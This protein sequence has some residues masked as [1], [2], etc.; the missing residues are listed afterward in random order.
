MRACAAWVE[1]NKKKKRHTK[2]TLARG[3]RLDFD[4]DV[5][6]FRFDGEALLPVL[7]FEH[8]VFYQ[9]TNSRERGENPLIHTSIP[10]VSFPFDPARL[11]AIFPLSLSLRLLSKQ[12]SE[13]QD[14]KCKITI[15]LMNADAFFA[16]SF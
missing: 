4:A 1:K 12:Q 11:V 16:I 15:K 8:S 9:G 10:P 7:R 2:T 3:T 13:R 5:R 14:A 6:T